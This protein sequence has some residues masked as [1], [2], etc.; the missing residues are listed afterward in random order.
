[1]LHLFKDKT[2]KIL[3]GTLCMTSLS[4]C[5]SRDESARSDHFDGSHYFNPGHTPSKG[6]WSVLK[7]RWTADPK[8]WPVK[9]ENKSYAPRLQSLGPGEVAI[10]FVNHATV[11]VQTESFNFLTDPVWSERVSPFTWIG[12]KRARE[13]GLDFDKLPTIHAVLVSHNHYDHLDLETLK[14]LNQKFKPQFYVG[15]GDGKLLNENGIEN[16]HEMDWWQ[17]NEIGGAKITFMPAMHW[18]GRWLNDRFKCLWGSYGIDVQGRKIYFA[19]DTGYADHFIKI[20]ERWGSPDLAFLPIGAYE[21]R[22]FMK[23][24][25]MNPEE[26][27]RAFLDLAAKKALGIHFGTFQLTDEGIDEPTQHLKE[28]MVKSGVAP[29]AFR[30]LDQGES[31]VFKSF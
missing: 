24:Y 6:F 3:L 9:V 27:V 28:A 16:V 1:M 5:A 21:P 18:S 2:K 13:P 14:R 15:L 8:K 31:W 17:T 20:R 19:G 7:W 22:W 29:E 26:A 12:P 25:H 10:T 11:L 30:A 23:D 4:A